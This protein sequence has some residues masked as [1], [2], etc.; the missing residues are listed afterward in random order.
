MRNDM[1]VKVIPITKE[2]RDGYDNMNWNL[3]NTRPTR[4]SE[5]F[6]KASPEDIAELKQRI[7]A[8]WDYNKRVQESFNDRH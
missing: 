3:E 6:F 8:R 7:Q 5:D 1:S 4:T 2:Y